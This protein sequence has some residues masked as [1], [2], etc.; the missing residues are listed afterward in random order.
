VNN[1]ITIYSNYDNKEFFESL[2]PN[3]KL[4][5]KKL[6][7]I[8]LNNSSTE[9]ILFFCPKDLDTSFINKFEGFKNI[10]FILNKKTN[11]TKNLRNSILEYPITINRLKDKVFKFFADQKKLF[12]DIEINDQRIINI[13]NKKF[14]F[15][16]NIEKEIF[17]ELTYHKTV[18]RKYL[19]ENILKI[20]FKV[21][22]RSLDSHLSRIRK[23]LQ[24]IN[25][26]IKIISRSENIICVI[27]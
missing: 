16:T 10:L 15:F 8:K 20:N 26:K 9:N 4:K 3:F 21:E 17:Q 27:S 13:D 18:K 5:F 1:Q 6:E 19:E 22:T 24:T 12:V 2:L 7:H 23:K 11:L 25:S 14:C